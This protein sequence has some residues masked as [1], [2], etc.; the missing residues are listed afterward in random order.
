MAGGGKDLR[1][2][3][4]FRTTLSFAAIAIFAT[5]AVL[6]A[7]SPFA[8]VVIPGLLGGVIVSLVLWYR[9][10]HSPP[11]EQ[12]RDVFGSD[13]RSTDVINFSSVRVAGVGGLGLVIVAATVALEFERVAMTMAIGLL[14]G[15]LAA[16]LLIVRRRRAGLSGDH[17]DPGARAFL[18]AGDDAAALRSS[19]PAADDD[20]HIGRPPTLAARSRGPRAPEKLS[21]DPQV[22]RRRL[23][24][25]H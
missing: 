6:L 16:F 24:L 19:R 11:P 15:S 22:L 8:V 14:G 21:S 17:G 2:S 20:Q 25:H 5:G 7:L 13:T 10:R 12:V 4:L 23:A 9:G 3:D 1:S 18:R